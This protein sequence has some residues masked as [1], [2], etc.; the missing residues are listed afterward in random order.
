MSAAGVVLLFAFCGLLP[1][2]HQRLCELD[3]LLEHRD[4]PF[5][6]LDFCGDLLAH[7]AHFV[8]EPFVEVAVVA[9]AVVV[10][11]VGLRPVGCHE[12]LNLSQCLSERCGVCVRVLDLL[13]VLCNF[14]HQIHALLE[15]LR[16]PVVVRLVLALQY[17]LLVLRIG[18]VLLDGPLCFVQLFFLLPDGLHRCGD[19]FFGPPRCRPALLHFCLA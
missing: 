5:V 10:V 18:R 14:G 2:V 9:V 8:G 11:A 19:F 12:S 13:D 15:S 16:Q 1:R 7:D 4:V 3:R 6:E 17:L